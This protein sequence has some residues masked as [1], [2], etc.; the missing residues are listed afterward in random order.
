MNYKT[1]EK[2]SLNN[3]DQSRD[4]LSYCTIEQK[5]KKSKINNN[6]KIQHFSKNTKRQLLGK[7]VDIGFKLQ[8]ERGLVVER[9]EKYTMMSNM[10]YKDK[11]KHSK[12]FLKLQ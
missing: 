4:G 5:D 10:H 1:S 6:N 3:R 8:R 7:E 9:K 12:K 2:C 11:T